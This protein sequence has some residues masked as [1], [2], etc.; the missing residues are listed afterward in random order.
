MES[1]YDGQQGKIIEVCTGPQCSV[2]GA[3]AVQLEIEDLVIEADDGFHIQEAGCRD[4][5]TMGPNV[6]CS[7]SHFSKVQSPEECERIAKEIGMSSAD[8]ADPI[9]ST[10]GKMMRRKANRKRWQLLR[11]IARQKS[12]GVNKSEKWKK[13]LHELHGLELRAAESSNSASELNQRADRR[14]KRFLN[15]V[16][17]TS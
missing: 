5:C 3:S 7:G 13:E 11:N 14:L 2:S 1:E 10:V 17:D 16:D 12:A 9:Q 4:F 6:Y 15:Y 8:D